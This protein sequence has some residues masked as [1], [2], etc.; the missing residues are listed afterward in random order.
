[1]VTLSANDLKLMMPYQIAYFSAPVYQRKTKPWES[2]GILYTI[3]QSSNTFFV[4]EKEQTDY[5]E[6]IAIKVIGSLGIGWILTDS[7]HRFVE[8]R[9]VTQDLPSEKN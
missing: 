5:A 3:D 7:S 4:L 6:T 1:M 9:D 2:I 8:V